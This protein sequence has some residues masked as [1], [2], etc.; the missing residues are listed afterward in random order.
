MIRTLAPPG[1][2]STTD[3]AAPLLEVASLRK[4]FSSHGLLP[5]RARDQVVAVDDVSFAVSRGTTLGIVGESGSGKST[6]A[7]LIARLLEPTAG[8]VRVDGVDFTKLRGE[9]LRR[10]R[11]DVQVVFQD[12]LGSFDPRRRIDAALKE[13]L[14][15]F[16]LPHDD[17]RVEELLDLVGL[18]GSYARRAPHQLSGG[19]RQRVAVARALALSPKV[20]ICDEAVASLDASIQAQVINLLEELQERLSLTYVFISHDLS[21]VRHISDSIVVMWHGVAVEQGPADQVIDNPS[22]AYTRSLLAAIP[23]GHRQRPTP[24]P[25]ATVRPTAS[26]SNISNGRSQVVASSQGEAS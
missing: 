6:T 18:P 2:A 24:A 8:S 14:R 5:G 26:V 11:R 12:P 1:S 23:G 17:S 22:H 9:A 7:R 20:L 15:A 21:L 4:E 16:D 13:P 25:A 3:S 19:Q 10:R